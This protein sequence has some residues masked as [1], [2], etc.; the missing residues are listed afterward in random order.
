MREN[1]IAMV[2]T[3]LK[4]RQTIRAAEDKLRAAFSDMSDLPSYVDSTLELLAQQRKDLRH[5]LTKTLC[6]MD[7]STLVIQ[8][9]VDSL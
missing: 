2:N 8:T 9:L 3:F 7:K 5:D 1:V 6:A 4:K